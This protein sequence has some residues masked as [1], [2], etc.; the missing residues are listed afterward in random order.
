M[1]ALYQLSYTPTQLS[2]EEE[3]PWEDFLCKS[4]SLTESMSLKNSETQGNSLGFRKNT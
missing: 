3:L 2:D 4:E 1:D